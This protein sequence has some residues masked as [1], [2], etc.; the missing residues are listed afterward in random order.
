[1]SY[2]SAVQA[3][4]AAAARLV[5]QASRAV[6]FTGAGI[7]TESGIPDFRSPGGLWEKFDPNDF[8]YQRFVASAET[9]KKM[10][11]WGLELYPIMRDAQP[12]AGHLALAEL[13]QRGR[14]RSV[15]TQNID[16]LHQRAGSREVIELH[17]NATRVAC[18]SCGS[19]CTR[20]ALHERLLG[21]D[22]DPHCDCGGILKSKVIAFGQAMPE[23]ETSNA[24]EEAGACD[25]MIAVG[26]S[27]V[28]FPAADMVPTAVKAGANLVLINLE[29]TQFDR[30]ASVVI[31]AKAGE[32]LPAIVAA[33]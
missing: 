11:S 3:E 32:A 5:S 30:M 13:E 7:S 15:I 20:D 19:E 17:G 8:T 18:L 9:R 4:I 25:L 24:Y 21:G 33:L 14:L 31:R 27:L 6:A 2:K 22:M 12:N 28:V 10:W 23:P 1:V 29:P 16:A 26:S